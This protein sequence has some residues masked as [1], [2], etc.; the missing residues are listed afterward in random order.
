MLLTHPELV[1]V[2]KHSFLCE[3]E[4]RLLKVISSLFCQEL[5]VDDERD[6][7][8]RTIRTKIFSMNLISPLEMRLNK[9]F[10]LHSLRVVNV[11]DMIWIWISKIPIP[12]L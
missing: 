10:A 3:L 9:T 1:R 8:E 11:I 5:H 12:N 4:R 2:Q 7:K 6:F